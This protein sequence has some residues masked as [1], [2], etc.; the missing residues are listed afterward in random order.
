MQKLNRAVHLAAGLWL[1][2]P[3]PAPA[4]TSA[5]GHL[6]AGDAEVDITPKESEKN[7]VRISCWALT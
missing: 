1:A 5:T 7:A 6:R 2:V 3:G 4:Q